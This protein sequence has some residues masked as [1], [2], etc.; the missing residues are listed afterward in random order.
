M[1]NLSPTLR[2]VLILVVIAAAV[3]AAGAEQGVF[4]LLYALRILFIVAMVWFV[5]SLWRSR[6]G[7]IAMWSRRARGVFYGA[8]LVALGNLIASFALTYPGT[9]LERL[10]FFAVFGLTGF[11]MWRVWKNE[12]TYGY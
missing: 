5:Y 2:G 6:R 12:H 11:A 7:E 3:T 10:V 1:R 8:A 9:G 4:W